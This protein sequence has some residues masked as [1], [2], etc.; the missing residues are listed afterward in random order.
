[1]ALWKGIL[2]VE[3]GRKAE[4]HELLSKLDPARLVDEEAK[5]WRIAMEKS[6]YAT[7]T[8]ASSAPKAKAVLRPVGTQT[9]KPGSKSAP[10]IE[11]KA[12][13]PTPAKETK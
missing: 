3:L 1:M 7:S 12:S 8:S 5:L 13:A 4:G 9:P 2:L 10:M 6:Q 11:S